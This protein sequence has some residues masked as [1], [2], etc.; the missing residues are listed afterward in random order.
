L[1][2][3]LEEVH[4]DETGVAIGV[5]EPVHNELTLKL[6]APFIVGACSLQLQRDDIGG[7]MPVS[8]CVTGPCFIKEIVDI[9]ALTVLNERLE[10]SKRDPKLPVGLC[11]RE[12]GRRLGGLD[13]SLRERFV[14]DETTEGKGAT[15]PR[16]TVEGRVHAVLF[17]QRVRVNVTGVEVPGG[18][19]PSAFPSVTPT[20]LEAKVV[21]ASTGKRCRDTFGES[22]EQVRAIFAN[23]VQRRWELSAIGQL[24]LRPEEGRTGVTFRV[25][26]CHRDQ[27][28]RT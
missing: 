3:E 14:T 12:S 13:C 20:P 17:R 27:S 28:Q 1:G 9:L 15:K 2:R 21:Q 24:D 5:V 8:S 23:A 7:V 25:P 11:E 26:K 22:L 16:D 4:A 6:L 18:C 19:G 10:M